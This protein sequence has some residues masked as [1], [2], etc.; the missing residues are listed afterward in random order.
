MQ[1]LV[2]FVLLEVCLQ[3]NSSPECDPHNILQRDEVQCH[4]LLQLQKR[5]SSE[6]GLHQAECEGTW[7]GLN[8]WP[9][10]AVGK[11]VAI[12]CPHFLVVITGKEGVVYRNCT[13]DGWSQAF[14]QHEIACG[15]DLIQEDLHNHNNIS[16]N[17]KY[18]LHV[19][20]MYSVGYGISLVS[21]IIAI[22]ILS[23]FRKLH[24]TRNY[25]HIQLFVSFVLR[26]LSIFVK[27]FALFSAEDMY[28][29][30]VYPVWCKIV[31]VFFHYCIM[32]NYSWLMVEALHL[33]TLLVFSFF[34]ERKY[35]WVYI[36]F[37][38]GSPML[39]IIAWSIA[40]KLLED[41]GCWNIKINTGIWWIISGPIITS[42]IINC[43]FFLSIIRIL[44]LKLKTPDIRGTDF[45]QYTRLAKSTLLLIP[46]FGVYYILF[47]FFNHDVR[48]LPWLFF[49]L[50]LAS[51]QG[52]V[53]AVLYCFLN[54][55][56]QSEVQRKWK[57]WRL[58][59]RLHGQ[60]R[61]HQNSISHSGGAVT[62]ES[63]LTRDQR[64]PG[65]W[66]SSLV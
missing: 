31:V 48:S 54:G 65:Q 11:T 29:C 61:P 32:A 53:V 2:L 63:L 37:G 50:A 64:S 23:V 66:E 5:N 39:F 1:T 8:C 51:I 24:C 19:R 14:P 27:D 62:Q 44:V 16:E 18:F 33:H 22:G 28:K 45:Y 41:I 12:P 20:I 43:F 59:Q 7:D 57:R 47:T 13:R 15:Y 3:V 56:V 36:V 49:E 10:S 38:W 21:L 34:S 40:K 17:P 30:H 55:E 60:A 4:K 46:L 52:F 9:A 6:V 26:A 58:K 25:I 35:F 42:I